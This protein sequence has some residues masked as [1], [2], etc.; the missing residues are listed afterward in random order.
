M[1]FNVN[2]C[3]VMM[4]ET[5]LKKNKS[6]G[7][8]HFQKARMSSDPKAQFQYKHKAS[9]GKRNSWFYKIVI[10]PFSKGTQ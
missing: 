3:F 2:C 5:F 8:S 4:I 1:L 6:E 9:L 7:P 10:I